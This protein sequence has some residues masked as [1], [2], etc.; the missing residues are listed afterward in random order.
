MKKRRATV[1]KR[2]YTW[3][4][5]TDLGFGS[6][7]TIRRKIRAGTFPAPVHVPLPRFRA[8]DLAR[9]EAAAE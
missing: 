6:R 8:E 1:E 2:L 3:K 5:V 9:L 4:E 7:A